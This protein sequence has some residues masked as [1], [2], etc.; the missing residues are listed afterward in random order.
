MFIG[1]QTVDA[2]Y[3]G[4]IAFLIV[5]LRTKQYVSTNQFLLL[6][7]HFRIVCLSGFV[8]MYQLFSLNK[9]LKQIQ[10]I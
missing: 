4:S 8:C 6:R 10:H 5:V 7:V 3:Y 1:V 2:L 9:D